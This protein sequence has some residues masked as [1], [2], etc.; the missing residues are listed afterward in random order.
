MTV[1]LCILAGV[2]PARHAARTNVI[3]ALHVA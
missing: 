2:A 3:E 1:G